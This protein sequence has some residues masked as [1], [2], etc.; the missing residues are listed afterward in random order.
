MAKFTDFSKKNEAV[1]YKMTK[2]HSVSIINGKENQKDLGTEKGKK[3]KKDS[4][5][6]TRNSQNA[7]KNTKMNFK[8]FQIAS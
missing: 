4:T 7:R 2:I 5:K 6:L 3:R 1:P 8:I